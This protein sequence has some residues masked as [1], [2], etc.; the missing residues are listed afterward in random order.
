MYLSEDT[1]ITICLSIRS[2]ILKIP[3]LK[4]FSVRLGDIERSELKNLNC[5]LD[6]ANIM[7][8]S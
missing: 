7:T 1:L 8:A 4:R 2:L 6:V 5:A 3:N